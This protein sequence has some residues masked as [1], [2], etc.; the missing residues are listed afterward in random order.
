[1]LCVI[2][3]NMN[4]NFVNFC[5]VFYDLSSLNLLNHI[6]LNFVKEGVGEA[7][8]FPFCLFVFTR[9][10]KILVQI[11]LSEVFFKYPSEN[12]RYLVCGR[13]HMFKIFFMLRNCN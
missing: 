6:Y 9:E 3:I 1:M 8:S 13:K 4:I 12:F 7:K 2:H 11:Q 10:W 5:I